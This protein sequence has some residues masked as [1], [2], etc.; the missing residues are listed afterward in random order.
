MYLTRPGNA[1]G[2]RH[3]PI[4]VRFSESC[5]LKSQRV[6]KGRSCFLAIDEQFIFQKSSYF[7]SSPVPAFS[8]HRVKGEITMNIL[9]IQSSILDPVGVLGEQL[10]RRGARLLTWLPEQEPSPP[11][12]DYGGLIVLGGPMNAHE[13]DQFPHLGQTVELIRQ[14]HRDGKPIMGVCLGAQ[15]IARA[16]GSKVY[17]HS[18]PELGF[19]PL[20]SADPDPQE[21]WLKNLPATLHLM[22]WHFDTFDL[23]EQAHLLMTND[24][25]AH[26]AYRIGHTIYGFQF[27]L[28]VTPDI[29]L[30]WLAMK[31][32]WIETNY[33][34]LERA[35][36]EQVEA[37]SQQ[38]AEF[39]QQVADAWIQLVPTAALAS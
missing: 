36:R 9:V 13:D 34:H 12:A 22:Q 5:N 7:R 15:L 16:F 18:A 6:A 39:A 26:Q 19:S 32:A 25:C 20:V 31:N 3:I 37:Y 17:Q 21:P 38:S 2:Y 10:V 4:T 24:L 11:Q 27:H 35:L 33:P 8:G 23:P 1:V 14:F 30:S 28:E 29:V